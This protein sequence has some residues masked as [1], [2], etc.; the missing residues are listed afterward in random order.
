MIKQYPRGFV[1]SEFTSK[2]VDKLDGL[3][4]KQGSW[5]DFTSGVE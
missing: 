5:R 3:Y 1:E 4:Q 2:E